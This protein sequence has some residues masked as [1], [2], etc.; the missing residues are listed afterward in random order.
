MMKPAMARSAAIF[1][2]MTARCRSGRQFRDLM[3]S[4][5]PAL[6]IERVLAYA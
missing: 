1:R 3:T 5:T 6:A 4:V 2:L